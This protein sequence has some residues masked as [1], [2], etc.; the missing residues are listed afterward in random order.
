VVVVV[1]GGLLV[2]EVLVVV[3]VKSKIYWLRADVVGWRWVGMWGV[4]SGVLVVV[5]VVRSV[6]FGCRLGVGVFSRCRGFGVHFVVDVSRWIGVAIFVAYVV[7]GCGV[8]AV[9]VLYF[10]SPSGF[11]V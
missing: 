5:L 9:G 4:G 8:V 1:A 7:V 11:L 3:P 6:G 2:V 10:R